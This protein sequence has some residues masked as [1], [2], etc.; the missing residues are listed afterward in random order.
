MN[1]YRAVRSFKSYGHYFAIAAGV[2]VWVAAGWL[3]VQGLIGWIGA[4]F[5]FG[6]GL[7]IGFLLFVF[8]DLTKILSDMLLPR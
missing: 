1:Q 5:G 3:L 6:L 7:F 4:M 8:V 2:M